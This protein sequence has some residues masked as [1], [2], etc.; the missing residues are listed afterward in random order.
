MQ[1][2]QRKL[3]IAPATNDEYAATSAELGNIPTALPAV[4]ERMNLTLFRLS[5]SI[6]ALNVLIKKVDEQ[7]AHLT[8]VWTLY[9]KR[10]SFI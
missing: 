10:D 1:S 8:S 6:E 9:S 7:C 3:S 4:K 5:K 2:G